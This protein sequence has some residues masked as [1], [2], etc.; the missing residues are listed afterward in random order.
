[1]VCTPLISELRMQRPVDLCESKGSLV[2]T[3]FQA[4]QALVARVCS[5]MCVVC[6]YEGRGLQRLRW[7]QRHQLAWRWSLDGCRAGTGVLGT[8]NWTAV[9]CKACS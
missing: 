6:A 9:L 5:L 2:Y 7:H 3:E 1:M 8:G 4:S